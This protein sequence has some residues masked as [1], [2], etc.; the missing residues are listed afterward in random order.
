MRAHRLSYR[1]SGGYWRRRPEDKRAKTKTIDRRYLSG[2][3]RSH[4]CRDFE[5]HW[6]FIC[7]CR[8]PYLCPS[9]VPEG[10]VCHSDFH[11]ARTATGFR[12]RVVFIL[13][14]TFRDEIASCLIGSCFFT[15]AVRI[16]RPG[17]RQLLQPSFNRREPKRITI[18]WSWIISTKPF[19][20]ARSPFLCVRY[21]LI[22][23]TVSRMR[24]PII[25]HR[26][27]TVDVAP[28]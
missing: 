1:R 10:A 20:S 12:Y 26:G 2:G 27:Y 17:K 11:P 6:L 14:C 23:V 8:F 21:Y 15:S 7:I 18:P 19:R 3:T 22:G 13:L 5:T 16:S 24:V 4:C 28:R 25:S 9:C